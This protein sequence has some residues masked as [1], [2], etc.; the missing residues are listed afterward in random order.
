MYKKKKKEEI[1][2]KIL[3]EVIMNIKVLV[4][5]L[6]ENQ[7]DLITLILDQVMKLGVL[8]TNK[9]IFDKIEQLSNLEIIIMIVMVLGKKV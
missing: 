3:K 6:L 5:D 1:E 2:I 4:V 8:F 7:A 9:I